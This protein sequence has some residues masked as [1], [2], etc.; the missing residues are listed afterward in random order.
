M[1]FKHGGESNRC[2]PDAIGRRSQPKQCA[3]WVWSAPEHCHW[4]RVKLGFENSNPCGR[5]ER[6]REANG[7]RGNDKE[8]VEQMRT[9]CVGTRRGNKACEWA[10][11]CI[12]M[13]RVK[14]RNIVL[15]GAWF[16]AV[17]FFFGIFQFF[18][19]LL[20]ISHIF[21]FIFHFCPFFLS[22]LHL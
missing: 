22:K 2:L 6:E 5:R 15:S 21:I 19:F 4:T 8:E 20:R 3:N 1:C 14:L 16:Q 10:F 18:L 17:S 13:Y 11:F 12:Y 9:I 7:L